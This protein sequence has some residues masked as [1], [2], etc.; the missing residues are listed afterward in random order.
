MGAWRK[1]WKAASCAALL[2]AAT[3]SGAS[4]VVEPIARLGLEGGYDSNALFDGSGGDRMG[5]VSPD[6]GVRVR[7]HR[8]ELRATYGGDLLYYGRIAPEGVWN[9]RA[10]L[11]TNARLTR[12][13]TLDLRGRG[14]VSSDP[15][16]LVMMGVFRPGRDAATSVVGDARL[17]WRGTRRIDVAGTFRERAAVFEDGTGGAMHAPGVEALYRFTRR[18]SLGGAYGLSLFQ[19]FERERTEHAWSHAARARG[20][21]RINR[22]LTLDAHAG[23]AVWQGGGDLALVPEAAVELLGAS[24]AWDFR[25]QLAHGLAIGTIGRPGL[26]DSLEF[27][28][29][30]RFRHRYELRGDGGFWRSGRAPDGASA[31]TGYALAGEA[32]LLVGGGVRLA[33][34]ATHFARLDDA[35]DVFARTTLGLRLG[36]ELSHR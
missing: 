14:A 33:I 10:A 18:L 35:S 1:T 31:V 26:V 28:A 32:A 11:T 22:R 19:G 13:L 25:V 17:A 2:L 29:S 15:I 20:T 8:W 23:P 21:Y 36:W 5:R 24:R 7:D 9:H 34:A 4:T 12:R 30:R 3:R 27:G 16:G 6:I